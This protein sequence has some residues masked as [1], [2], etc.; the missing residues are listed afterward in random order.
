MDHDA[1][2]RMQENAEPAFIALA[3]RLEAQGHAPAEVAEA[4]LALAMAR[5]E[6]LAAN[7]ETEAAIA[8]ARATVERTT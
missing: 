2:M 6:M 4:L 8:R 5:L 1:A 3:E 7:G